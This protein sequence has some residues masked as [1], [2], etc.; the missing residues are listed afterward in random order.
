M[1]YVSVIKAESLANCDI[2]VGVF[3]SQLGRSL[4]STSTDFCD[5]NASRTLESLDVQR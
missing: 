1:D 3:E 5:G 2:L 4:S